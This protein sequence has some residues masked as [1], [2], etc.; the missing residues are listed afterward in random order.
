MR[1]HNARVTSLDKKIK[2]GSR[3]IV[4]ATPLEELTIDARLLVAVNKNG[5]ICGV[6]KGG[7]GSIEPSL[8]NEMIQVIFFRNCSDEM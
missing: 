4:D 5:K 8:L 2:I 7:S 6:Q 1:V 3:H